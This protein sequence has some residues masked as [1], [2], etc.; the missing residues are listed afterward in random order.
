MSVGFHSSTRARTVSPGQGDAVAADR[1]PHLGPADRQPVEPCG[2]QV[3]VVDR[4]RVGADRQLPAEVLQRAVDPG[5]VG[6][7][8]PP[9]DDAGLA[10][11]PVELDPLPASSTSIVSDFTSIDPVIPV[12]ELARSPPNSAWTPVISVLIAA[13]GLPSLSPWNRKVEFAELDLGDAERA[14]VTLLV[15]AHVKVRSSRCGSSAGRRRDAGARASRSS[16]PSACRLRAH[17]SPSA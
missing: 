2:R 16:A 11:Q 15:L 6:I 17:G 1:C 9:E 12:I 8:A 5:S 7:V 3:K 13:A 10:A 14:W 4:D